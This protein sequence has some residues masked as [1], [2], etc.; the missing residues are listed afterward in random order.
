MNNK[1]IKTRPSQVWANLVMV[2]MGL[3]FSASIYAQEKK[4]ISGTV[5]DSNGISLPGASI[6]ENGSTNGTMTDADGKFSLQVTA[7]NTIKVSSVGF[8]TQTLTI[9][10]STG[11][12]L[13]FDLKED[14]TTLETVEVVSVGYGTMRK[15]DLTGAI[16]SLSA[17]DL[18]KGTIVSTEQILQGKVAGLVVMRGTGDPS[19]GSSLRLRGGTSLT[20]SNNPLIV[21]DGIPGVDINSVQA[22]DIK[23]VDVLK[24]ASATAIYG[25]RG[26]NGVIIIT[27]KGGSKGLSVVYNGF[28]G[29]SHA[30][31]HI[32]MLSANQWRNYV[33]DNALTD[34]VDYGGNTDWQD[35]LE[36]TAVTQSHTLNITSGK[37]E[38]GLRA[39]VSYLDSEGIVKTTNLNRLAVNASTYQYAWDK[40]LKFDVGV[41]ANIDKWHPLDY[42][43]FERAFNLNP[44]IPVRTATGE[45]SSVGG[46]LYEN[47]VEILTNRTSDSERHRVLGYF[48]TEAKIFNNFQAVANLSM[49]HNAMKGGIYKP[50]YAVLEGQ[51]E[52]GYGQRIYGDYTNAQL[53]TYLNYNK[54]SGKHSINAMAGYSFLENI[55]EG[56]GAQR[57]GFTTDLF[58]YNNL[59][60]GQDYRLG[61]V[62]SYK[63]KSRLVSFFGRANYSYDGKYMFTGTIRRD[64]SSRF[65]ANNKWGVFPSVSAAWRI[66][67]EDF[68]KPT[69]N[70]LTNLKIRAG[71]GVTGNQDGIGEYKSLSILGVGQDS[72]YDPATGNWSLAY[73]PTQ[74]P[75]PD[76]KWESTA[77][78]NVGIDFS[79]FNRINGTFEWYSKTTKDL[80][81]T[82]E[83]PQPPYLVGTML[84]NVGELSNK[85][86][87]LTLNA[88]VMKHNDFSWDANLTLAHNK[89]KIEKLSN[90]TYETDV[91][92]SGS[93]HG[94]SGMSNQY[95]QIIAE[96]YPVGTFWGYQYQGLDENGEFILSTEKQAIGNVQPDLTMGIGMNFTYKDFDLGFTG[97][98]SFGQKVLNATNMMLY[99][100]NRMPA[101]NIPDDFIGSAIT[102]AP[103]FSSYW[104]ED[105]SFFRLQTL[106][107]GYTVPLKGNLPK[108]RIYVLGENLFVLTKYKGTDPEVDLT[109]LS[110][111]GIDRFN[112]YPRPTTISVGLNI[113]LNH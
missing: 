91:I 18:V 83:V 6:T 66:A 110:T 74:N 54:I 77:Q 49:E 3:L 60:A 93:L 98:G 12:G 68:M 40:A 20:A 39:S 104:I 51:T 107:L 102:S 31:N 64:G 100:P 10:A 33:R 29:V 7:G 2:L 28:T 44:T 88:N 78:F 85:G 81:Y 25:S 70:W 61:D 52:D 4:L 56:F 92:Y 46:T 75:N 90:D 14:Q 97:Y 9:D 55:Y 84:A 58:D 21:V 67:G 30:S 94:L 53:E 27:T 32:D 16:T 96:G 99:D 106:T 41:Y 42:R 36:Q 87:E 72:Y 79:L 8:V 103:T 108:F 101:Y 76:L 34:A 24:D 26:A 45:F 37:E 65:G 23:S 105:A 89:Q 13:R 62:Y 111:P 69:E 63:G 109:G 5:Y 1:H 22:S 35:E 47:P 50:T 43:I 95:S 112:N 80:L 82:Y 15:S 11:S 57:S 71:Y 59:G 113:S 38:S 17:K 48:K 19:S 73:S 86:I